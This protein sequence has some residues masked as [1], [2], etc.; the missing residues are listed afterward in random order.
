M[1]EEGLYKVVNNEYTIANV[2]SLNNGILDSKF[3]DYAIR[4]DLN[5]T[6]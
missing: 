2:Q 4:E 3:C 1:V 6:R 5:V